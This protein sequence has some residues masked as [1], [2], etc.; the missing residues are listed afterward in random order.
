M[1]EEQR[2]NL[3]NQIQADFGHLLDRIF[4]LPDGWWIA[5][6]DFYE[7][8]GKNCYQLN[9]MSLLPF[10]FTESVNH[11]LSLLDPKILREMDTKSDQEFTLIVTEDDYAQGV[12][13][14]AHGLCLDCVRDRDHDPADWGCPVWNARFT[15]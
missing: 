13:N 5:R 4:V 10:P 8:V 9:L 11:I 2:N 12:R 7:V 15:S 14:G 3:R 6:P 1:L